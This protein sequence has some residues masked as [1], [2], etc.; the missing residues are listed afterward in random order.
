MKKLIA[1]NIL[2]T[3]ALAV[4]LV[5][6]DSTSAGLVN[7][8]TFDDGSADDVAGS[9]D[10]S[11]QGDLGF[12]VSMEGFGLAA[13]FDGDGDYI[14]LPDPVGDFDFGSYS[15]TWWA[16]ITDPSTVYHF[17]M[18][19]TSSPPGHGR[20]SM[21]AMSYGVFGSLVQIDDECCLGGP[22]IVGP[23]A[24]ADTWVHYAFTLDRITNVARYYV[25]GIEASNMDVTGAD[26]LSSPGEITMIG[27]AMNGDQTP[28]LDYSD[29]SG[30]MDDIGFFDEALTADQIVNVRLN[31][32]LPGP[33]PITIELSEGATVVNEQNETSD[34]IT[35]VLDEAPEA[36]VTV[37]VG[38]ET[39]DLILNGITDANIAVTL[40]FTTANWDTP[41]TVTV[42]AFD[43]T[44]EEGEEIVMMVLEGSSSDL[45]FVFKAG[46]TARVIDNDTLGVAIIE[47][48]N[49]T[50]VAED[51]ATTDSYDVVLTFAP[52]ADVVIAIDIDVLAEDP[53]QVERAPKDLTFTAGNWDTAQTVQVTAIDD[54]V[55]DLSPHDVTLT[56]SA[57]GGG[58]TEM[59]VDNVTVTISEN[60]CDVAGAAGVQVFLDGDINQDCLV[61]LV[62]F[63]LMAANFLNCSIVSTDVCVR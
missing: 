13:T 56:H 52:T 16:T 36:E 7:G 28:M 60:D 34:S 49:A 3:T 61:D 19:G 54:D 41:Q 1:K 57:S 21:D 32:I 55:V 23:I 12:A 62:D 29:M 15:V 43:D 4:L 11:L 53:N 63:A 42:G 33:A 10:G 25:D 44:V 59:A 24:P 14:V 45:D 8:Y 5:V 39:P 37:T 20:R 46:T 47:S 2:L 26:S 48:G 40:T 17:M 9:E 35:V 18:T 31:G 38:S 58:Y 27:H 6:S 30:M 22:Y 50:E 51:G